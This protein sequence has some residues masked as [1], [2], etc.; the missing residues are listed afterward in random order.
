MCVCAKLL[1][2]CLSLCDPMDCSPSDSSVHGILQARI[3][4]WVATPSSKGSS[5]FRECT[6]VSCLLRWQ[7]SLYHE[8]CLGSPLD[9]AVVQS[10]SHVQLFVT[11][12]TAGF[13]VLHF[14]LEFAQTHV[15]WISDGFQPSHSLSPPSPSAFSL[16]QQQGLF[17]ES[18]FCIRWPKYWS[19][20]FSIS[21]A[22][23]THSG[24]ISFRIDWFDHLE[25]H[26]TLKSL[27]QNHNS[28]TSILWCSAFFMVQLSHS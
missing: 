10:L 9:K 7:A 13:P 21:P 1:Q 23:P 12:W 27:L 24:L 25:T 17:N 28:K 11:L 19:F 18:A 26:G 16:S 14:L 5:L 6:C 3:L 15:H 4:E 20:R 8:R 2:L 22:K